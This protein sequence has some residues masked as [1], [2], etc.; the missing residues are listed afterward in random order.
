ML[1]EWIKDRADLTLRE[2][3]ER[4]AEHGITIEAPA[5][6]HP[7]NQRGLGFEKT[8]HAS[9]QERK[10]V[11]ADRIAWKESQPALDATKLVFLDETG[12]STNMTRTRG[13][14]PKGQRCIASVPHGHRKITTFIAGLRV[15]AVTAPMV[16]D[17]PMA[18][19]SWPIYSNSCVLRCALAIS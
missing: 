10:D 4:L 12:T 18:K 2:M 19:H 15:N 13:R 3:C 14:S 9:E 1:R 16:L 11:Q 6:W 8:L 17:G 5:L 7:L